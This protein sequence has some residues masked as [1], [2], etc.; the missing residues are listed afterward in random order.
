MTHIDDRGAVQEACGSRVLESALMLALLRRERIYPGTRK[1]LARFLQS[2]REDRA[3]TALERQL[4]DICLS[5]RP[6]QVE[7][8]ALLGGFEHFTA[9]RKRLMFD[10]YL[11]VLGATPPDEKVNLSA[12]EY[13]GHASWV[14]VTLSAVKILHAYGRGRPDLLRE[15]DREFLTSQVEDGSRR[16]VWEGHLSAHLLA[17]HAVNRFLPGSRLVR[18]DID[19][20]LQHRNPDGGLPFITDMTVWLTALAG[21]ALTRVD[22]DPALLRRMGDYLAIHQAPDGGWSYTESVTQT[23]VDDTSCSAEFL[24]ALDP[25]RYADELNRAGRYLT[26]I[27]NEDGGFPTYRRGHAS[28]ITMTA[29][30][31]SAL[32][33][34]WDRHAALLEPA[35][36][37]LLRTQKPDGTFERSWSRADAYAIS[38]ALHALSLAPHR[39]VARFRTGISQVSTLALRYLEGAQNPDGGWGHRSGDPSDPISTAHALTAS[40]PSGSAPWR[41]SGVRYLM[42]QQ[43]PD[44]GFTSVPDQAAP[45]PI[46]YDFPVLADIFV[47][48]ALGNTHHLLSQGAHPTERTS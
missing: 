5:D 44:G 21:L 33:P 28:E 47:L 32:A 38:R 13:H 41:L 35:V 16:E 36:A 3:L 19:R 26:H 40:L 17:L 10:T 2:Q 25:S 12:V 30:A 6:P 42:D 29:N 11:M 20:I 34:D 46:P 4:A 23:D 14:G 24:S 27:A 37:F 15:Q 7:V 45:R 18:E 9:A 1:S 31:I 39:H 8:E 43:E 48:K 22:T